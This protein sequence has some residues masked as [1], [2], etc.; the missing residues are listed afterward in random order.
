MTQWCHWVTPPLWNLSETPSYEVIGWGVTPPLCLLSS[1]GKRHCHSMS[2]K[3]WEWSCSAFCI[4]LFHA[5]RHSL[6]LMMDLYWGKCIYL[7]FV[8][9]LSKTILYFYLKRGFQIQ[10][11][12]SRTPT[13]TGLELWGSGP[14]SY[15][16]VSPMLR[17][18]RFWGVLAHPPF[19]SL[20]GCMLG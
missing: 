3:R 1:R 17:A 2:V 11:S 14:Y 5:D 13:T 12:Y 16:Q 4:F 6:W 19:P 20:Q 18:Y 15:H 10:I 7:F 8:R 9:T